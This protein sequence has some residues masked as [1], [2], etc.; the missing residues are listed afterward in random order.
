MVALQPP[1]EAFGRASITLL[2]Q[3]D[4]QHLAMFVHRAPQPMRDTAHYDTHLI[5]MP[6]SATLWFAVAQRLGQVGTKLGA[7]DPDRLMADVDALF[8]QK[9][10]HVPVGKQKAVAKIDC[11]GDDAF[12]K[13][14]P[15][16]TSG[17]FK[18]PGSLPQLKLS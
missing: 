16:R 1:K 5:Q 3:Q 17:R 9:F 15:F 14:I 12:R 10:L 4:V 11:V 6:G 18:H 13:A 8:E 2:L 7:S